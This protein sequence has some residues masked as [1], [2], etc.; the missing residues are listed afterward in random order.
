MS[1]GDQLRRLLSDIQSVL[2]RLS[3]INR[4]SLVH[5]QSRHRNDSINLSLQDIAT[6][7]P[8]V[9]LPSNLSSI[10]LIETMQQNRRAVRMKFMENKSNNNRNNQ[11]STHSLTSAIG[12]YFILAVLCDPSAKL[13]SPRSCEEFTI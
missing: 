5:I 4:L 9:P 12:F 8:N 13:L 6:N 1:D 11:S 2:T 10:N 3:K 7:L